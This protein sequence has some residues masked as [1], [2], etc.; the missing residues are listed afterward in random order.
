MKPKAN[1]R[2]VTSLFLYLGC[3]CV[4]C[5]AHTVPTMPSSAWGCRFWAQQQQHWKVQVRD[6]Q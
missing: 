5:P 6:P 3:F 4:C 1:A 2:P